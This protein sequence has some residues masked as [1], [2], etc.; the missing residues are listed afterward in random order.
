MKDI[1]KEMRRV[2]NLKQNEDEKYTQAKNDAPCSVCGS[3]EFVQKFRNVVGEITGSICGN[4][5]LFGGSISGS[6]D[7][8]TKTL[9]VLS[10]RKCENERKIATWKYVYPKYEFWSFMHQ[11]YFKVENNF[12]DLYEIDPFFLER[13]LETRQYMIDNKNYDYD[14]YNDCPN[15]S[16]KVWVKSGFKIPKIKKSFLFWT[17]ERY[18]TWEELNI[19]S[20]NQQVKQN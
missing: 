3:K 6:I 8:Y 1:D 7:G 16:T 10:C 13:P 4:F 14:F 19:I 17:W 18:P 15:W 2:A 11:F 5:S 12:S 20:S 9:P